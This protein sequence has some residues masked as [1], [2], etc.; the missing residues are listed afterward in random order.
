MSGGIQMAPR[1]E[2]FAAKLAL[3]YAELYDGISPARGRVSLRIKD[4]ILEMKNVETH[5]VT[6]WR[7]SEMREVADKSDE[8]ALT[9][10]P[11][12]YDP[13]RLIVREV[14]AIRAL[15]QTGERF[16]PLSGP[17][18]QF[19]RLALVAVAACSGIFGL[20]FG[21]IPIFASASA[22]RMPVATE[23]ALGQQVYEDIYVAGG[24][25][26]CRDPA[27]VAAMAVMEARL[28]DGV[29][30]PLPLT[31]R[32]VR[33]PSVNAT[34]A[35]GGHITLHQGLIN[36][37]ESPEEV[38]AVLAHEI[39]HVAH[40][41]GTRGYLRNMGSFGVVGLV[42]G[43]V[44]GVGGSFVAS[45]LVDASYSREAETEADRFAHDMMINAGL[46]P[47]AMAQF[48][49]RLRDEMG[50]NADLG[51]LRHLS[52]HP[53][54]LDRIAAASE[55]AAQAGPVGPPVLTAEEWAAVQN[56]C[57]ASVPLGEAAEK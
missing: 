31:V 36:S 21:V 37:A 16:E 54:L 30:L 34:A 56:M 33:D 35:P 40:R 57:G 7:L 13:A 45:M 12:N 26:E 49:T 19:I 22:A 20:L 47:A 51:A 18:G 46:P 1:N 28:T 29:N 24:A 53:E 11:D 38:A 10:A 2:A 41:D 25:S 55:A 23:V 17:R 15:A 9:F 27:G 32:V 50:E 48:F 4:D 6:N 52:T 42:F 39:G 8:D 3:T 44:F 43:D 14:S 5:V